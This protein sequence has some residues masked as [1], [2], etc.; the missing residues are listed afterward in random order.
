VELRVSFV[1]D[2]GCDSNNVVSHKLISKQIRNCSNTLCC[3]V[4]LTERRG[5]AKID[6]QLHSDL[7]EIIDIGHFIEE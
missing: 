4:V 3:F 6:L 1:F 2:E 5:K 7:L